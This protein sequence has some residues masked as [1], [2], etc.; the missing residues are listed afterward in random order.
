M[1]KGEHEERKKRE[2]VGWGVKKGRRKEGKEKGDDGKKKGGEG[3]NEE[4]K[5]I[6]EN[7]IKR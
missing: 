2:Q 1:I 7:I 3:G 4:R 5:E 6:D